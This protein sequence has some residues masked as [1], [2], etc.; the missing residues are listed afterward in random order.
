[1]LNVTGITGKLC[2]KCPKQLVKQI[3]SYSDYFNVISGFTS[4]SRAPGG[5]VTVNF[6]SFL[7][8]KTTRS[9]TVTLIDFRVAFELHRV[10]YRTPLSINFQIS[11]KKHHV[12]PHKSNVNSYHVCTGQTI[13][14]SP[15]ITDMNVIP[16]I[17]AALYNWFSLNDEIL[18]AN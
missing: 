3:S 6:V 11:K 1:M 15:L 18:W 2:N 4:N 16:R 12:L 14:V 7:H 10:F 9:N 17:T 5:N 8:S 13:C